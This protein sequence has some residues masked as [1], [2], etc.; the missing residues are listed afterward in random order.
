MTLGHLIEYSTS[1]LSFS[2]RRLDV[3]MLLSEVL[4][5]NRMSLYTHWDQTLHKKQIDQFESLFKLRKKGLPIA[6]ILK[7]KEF[8][9][10]DFLIKPGVFIPRPETE[11]LVSA[12]LS[13]WDPKKKW[14][15]MEFG[16]GSGCIG[17]SLLSYLQK[18][19]LVALDISD[20]ALE[21]SR[22]NAQNKGLANRVIFIKQDVVDLCPSHQYMKEPFDLIVAN[23]PYI[24]FNDNRVEQGV[25]DFEPKLAIFSD[26]NGLFHIKSWFNVAS[27]FLRPQGSYFFE[28]G[29]GQDISVL[30]KQLESMEKVKEFKDLS[31]HVRVIE[32]QKKCYG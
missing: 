27:V 5:Y 22:Q 1:L 21:I 4:G 23:P 12:V 18:S 6:Y 15:I 25:I 10:Q 30:E 24:S 14:N 20:K 28:I 16:S 17:L 2:S 29:A 7:R 32:F 13:S 31:G 26:E 8:Y 19:S 11:T 9:G 3:E